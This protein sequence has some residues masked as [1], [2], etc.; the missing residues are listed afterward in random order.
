MIKDIVVHPEKYISNK[1]QNIK[2]NGERV[3]IL[4]SNSAIRDKDGNVVEIIS[5]G[6]PMS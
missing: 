3:D 5:V 1:N 2:K 4:W 6:N